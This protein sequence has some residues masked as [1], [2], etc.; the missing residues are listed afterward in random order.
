LPR[1]I[2]QRLSGRRAGHAAARRHLEFCL[3]LAVRDDADVDTVG[4]KTLRERRLHR[5]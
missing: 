1:A 5:P 3:E 2:S 4:A